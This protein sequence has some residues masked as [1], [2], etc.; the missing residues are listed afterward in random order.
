VKRSLVVATVLLLAAC[1]P[2][3]LDNAQA[4]KLIA[5]H[6]SF[7]QPVDRLPLAPD[8]VE[9]SIGVD[10]G[11]VEGMWRI[12]GR[13]SRGQPTR[14]LTEKGKQGF[15]D[16]SGLLATPGRRE[17]VELT[18]LVEDPNDRKHRSAEFTWRYQ[19]P[20]LVARYTGL[21]GTYKGKAELRYD[22]EW[23]V[24][25]LQADA[26]P[27][28]FQWTAELG[29][30]LRQMLSAEQEAT[31]QRVLAVE[32]QKFMT[33]DKRPYTITVA[34]VQVTMDDE[35]SRYTVSY[36]ELVNCK[37]EAQGASVTLRVEGIRQDIVA[38]AAPA[39]LPAFQKICDVVKEAH[40]NWAAHNREIADRGPLGVAYSR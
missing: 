32:P 35:T 3:S 27:S 20:A 11:V 18:S 23:K 7:A 21:E 10:A 14:E 17:I 24:E 31:T 25:S 28:S 22:H 4:A 6:P 33:P 15:K 2:K 39:N 9:N 5:A 40:D 16:A 34:D 38:V 36:L 30:Q 19:I 26:K 8:I 37:V 13:G 29:G 1:G 12:G